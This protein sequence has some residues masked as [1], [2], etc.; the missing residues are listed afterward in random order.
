L[1]PST[2]LGSR[3]AASSWGYALTADCFDDAGFRDFYIEHYGEGR[4]PLCNAGQAFTSN[5]C[6]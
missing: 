2:T 6:P 5:P 3:W 1:T 4:E